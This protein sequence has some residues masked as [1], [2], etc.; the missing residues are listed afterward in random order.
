MEKCQVCGN[1][2]SEEP[3]QGL[4]S[5]SV[6]A[7]PAKP[8]SMDPMTRKE[9]DQAMLIWSKNLYR[10]SVQPSE[11]PI[12]ASKSP[13]QPKE[14]VETVS[15]NIS[16]DIAELTK[17][18][19]KLEKYCKQIN[20]ARKQDRQ[21]HD[22]QLN[23]LKQEVFLVKGINDDS[24]D[25]LKRVEAIEAWYQST[26][27]QITLFQQ[28]SLEYGLSFD[29]LQQKVQS[30]ED[31]ESR[32]AS[33]SHRVDVIEEWRKQANDTIVSLYEN[34]DD[35]KDVLKRVEAIEA[36][37]QSAHDQMTL[38]QQTSLEYSLKLDQLQQ[39]LQFLEDIK[40]QNSSISNRIDIIEVW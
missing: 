18:L 13:V 19:G 23:T 3:K 9:Y 32:N 31:V 7:C 38:F 36:S 14:K 15:E 2:I 27:N 4:R 6:C 24:K 10:Q 30:L 29:Q 16:S 33:T 37:H 1:K 11:D 20:E 28:T 25:I 5:C 35:S 17:K 34:N 21:K 8:G 22:L 40:S 39:R 26:H 12:S